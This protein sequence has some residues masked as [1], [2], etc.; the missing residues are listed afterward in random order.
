LYFSFELQRPSF[1]LALLPE[2]A[3]S[4]DL[5]DQLER[6]IYRIIAAV[7]QASEAISGGCKCL[8]EAPGL[9]DPQRGQ[10]MPRRS[11][12]LIRELVEL[13]V[14]S[15]TVSEYYRAAVD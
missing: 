12:A 5:D 3:F 14:S 11:A 9:S 13:S 15:R 8:P 7:C 1:S 4:G 2:P 6:A 10:A